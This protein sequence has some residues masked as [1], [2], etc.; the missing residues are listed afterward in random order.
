MLSP[1]LTG[2]TQ[3]GKALGEGQWGAKGRAVQALKKQRTENT[4]MHYSQEL[5]SEHLKACF[6]CT[7]RHS[8]F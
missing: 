7:M 8:W 3:S 6:L 2:I 1:A 4:L 5:S